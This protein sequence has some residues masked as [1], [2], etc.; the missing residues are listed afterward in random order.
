MLITRRG[1]QLCL[2]KQVDHG[3]LA[4]NIAQVWGG[5]PFEAPSP[6]DSAYLAAARH[7]EG[8]RLWDERPAFNEQEGRPLHFLEIAMSDHVP[9]YKAGVEAVTELDP[10][11]GLLVGMHW[12][13]L[14]RGRW[15]LQSNVEDLL[16]ADRTPVQKLQDQA[17]ADEEARWISLKTRLWHGSGPRAALE[18][19]LWHNY[20]LL[21]AWDLLSLFVCVAPLDTPGA[22]SEVVLLSSTLRPIDHQPGRRRIPA[23]PTRIGQPAVDLDLTVIEPGVVAIEPYPFKAPAVTFTVEASAIPDRRYSS[24]EMPG[25][26]KKAQR[27]TIAC[28]MRPAVTAREPSATGAR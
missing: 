20:G 13:G 4:G 2:V 14:Y 26:M 18:M 12:S 3:E 9:L 24:D 27:L 7:D 23:V 17:V 25:V 11:A 6:F 1:N 21:Q 28:E 5:G 19:R 16:Q 10:Y 8:W 15:G 22:T